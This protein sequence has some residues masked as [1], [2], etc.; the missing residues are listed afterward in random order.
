MAVYTLAQLRTQAREM[1][2]QPLTGNP[3]VT[4][5]E[6]TT[7]I[8]QAAQDLH[9]EITRSNEDYHLTAVEFTLT[10]AT[11]NTY[12]LPDNFYKLRGL[13]IQDGG[14]WRKVKPFNFAERDRYRESDYEATYRLWYLLRFTPLVADA[15]ELDDQWSEYVVCLAAR[16]MRG[17]EETSTADIDGR[18]AMLRDRIIRMVGKRDSGGPRRIADLR[19][20]RT[21]RRT[22]WTDDGNADV[23]T[24]SHRYRVIQNAVYVVTGGWI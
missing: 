7:Y 21:R 10:A 19:A 24:T 18:I 20:T 3:L 6:L 23:Y 11:G 13:D 14:E 22:V 16:K 8:N 12:T 4:E 15:D 17:K 9:D 1:A 2:D 5:S